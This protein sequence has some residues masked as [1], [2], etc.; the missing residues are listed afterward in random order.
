MYDV[1]GTLVYESTVPTNGTRV[2]ILSEWPREILAD[3]KGKTYDSDGMR[4]CS[5]QSAAQSSGHPGRGT[6][7]RGYVLYVQ[8]S[9]VLCT[10]EGR[11]GRMRGREE[12]GCCLLLGGTRGAEISLSEAGLDAM[13]LS[14]L[15][16]ASQS[17]CQPGEMR[18]RKAKSR[19]DL[20]K[21][22]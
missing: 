2:T 3:K 16:S 5:M 9:T 12:K 15:F 20:G 14:S 6:G 10:R 19:V 8:Y 21:E 18:N 1:E 17:L 22:G 7:K 13:S 4:T 11:W